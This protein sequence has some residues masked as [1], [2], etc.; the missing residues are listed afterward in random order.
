MA[1]QVSQS[2]LSGGAADAV[3]RVRQGGPRGQDEARGRFHSAG[4][5]GIRWAMCWRP[6][7]ALEGAGGSWAVPR[8]VAKAV[9]GGWERGWEPLGAGRSG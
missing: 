2:L 7:H 5:A 6:R 8:A 3:S 4:R 9:P 1:G